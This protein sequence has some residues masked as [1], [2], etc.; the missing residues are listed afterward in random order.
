MTVPNVRVLRFLLQAVSVNHGKPRDEI[1]TFEEE[2]QYP[3]RRFTFR[4]LPQGVDADALSAD[5]SPASIWRG[6]CQGSWSQAS[7]QIKQ[8]QAR[9]VLTR[10]WYQ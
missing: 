3:L 6:G 5:S 1:T 10:A 8:A 7:L 4:S 9:R 2:I